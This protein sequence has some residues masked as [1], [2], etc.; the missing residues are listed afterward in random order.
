MQVHWVGMMTASGSSTYT[1]GNNC[2]SYEDRDANNAP[3]ADSNFADG[4]ADLRFDFP[5]HIDT[6]PE[7]NKDASVSNLFYWNNIMHDVWHRY[8]FDELSGN[9]QADN[10][11]RGG[12][13]GDRVKAETLDDIWEARNNANFYTPSDGTSPVMQMYVWQQPVYDTIICSTLSGFKRKVPYIQATVSKPL[14]SPFT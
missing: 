6:I 12:L 7:I 10:F 3:E 4:G 9:L 2:L 8:G 14:K 1:R 13:S 11:Y 5:L